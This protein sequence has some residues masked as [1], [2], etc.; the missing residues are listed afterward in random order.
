M[1]DDSSEHKHADTDY[2]V[3]LNEEP[4]ELVGNLV[5]RGLEAR[6]MVEGIFIVGDVIIKTEAQHG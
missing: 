4:A 2:T 1:I 6:N 3:V 5:E